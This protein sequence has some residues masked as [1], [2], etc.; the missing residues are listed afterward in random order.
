MTDWLLT[1]PFGFQIG[2]TS[3]EFGIVMHGPSVP[4]GPPAPFSPW[5]LAT[6]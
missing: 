6:E 1:T 4:T 5:Y 2:S 3:V